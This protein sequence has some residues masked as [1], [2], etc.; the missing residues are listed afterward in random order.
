MV[1]S[2]KTCVGC[3]LPLKTYSGLTINGDAYHIVCWDTRGRPIP[4]AHPAT[5]TDQARPSTGS[6]SAR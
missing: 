2:A 1:E 3:G 4:K 6:N 5:S